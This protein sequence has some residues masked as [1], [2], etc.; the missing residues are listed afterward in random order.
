MLRCSVFDAVAGLRCHVDV[1][2][3]TDRVVSFCSNPSKHD[4]GLEGTKRELKS[5]PTVPHVPILSL[6]LYKVWG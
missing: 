1:G 4:S 5:P 3:S 6:H 2:T